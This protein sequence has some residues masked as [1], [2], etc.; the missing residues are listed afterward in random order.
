MR[1][2]PQCKV[3]TTDI[4]SEKFPAARWQTDRDTNPATFHLYYFKHSTLLELLDLAALGCRLCCL[5]LKAHEDIAKNG[6]ATGLG[7]TDRP[8]WI[9]INS[10]DTW[11]F[12]VEMPIAEN[13]IQM[14]YA[15]ARL[16]LYQL[17]SS[18]ETGYEPDG[19][20]SPS[21]RAEIN[22]TPD[23][24]RAFKL[25]RSWIYQC[26]HHH[27][28]C[29]RSRQVTL[30]PRVLDVGLPDGSQ[31]PCLVDGKGKKGEYLTLSHV[32]G[33]NTYGL[34]TAANMKE[35]ESEISPSSL[36]KTF[37]DAIVITGNLGFRYVWIDSL[38][39]VQDSPEDW[40][41]NCHKMS[42][43]FG[44]STLT[45]ASLWSTK[46]GDGIFCDRRNMYPCNEFNSVR[47]FPDSIKDQ[48]PT[49]IRVAP[50]DL[51]YALHSFKLNKRGWVLQERILSP[52]TL[53]CWNSEMF[54]ECRVY[55]ASESQPQPLIHLGGQT[56]NIFQE[57][58]R[59]GLIG[60]PQGHIIAWYLIVEQYSERELT[61]PSDRLLA[62][63]GLARRFCST[64]SV[65]YSAGLWI[66][67]LHRGLLWVSR[68]KNRGQAS[69]PQQ[70][71]SVLAP[72]WSWGDVKTPVVFAWLI[73][74]GFSLYYPIAR[75]VAPSDAD[76]VDVIKYHN[77][78]NSPTGRLKGCIQMWAN[79]V[80]AFYT[81]IEASESPG[82]TCLWQNPGYCISHKRRDFGSCQVPC[83]LDLAY[84][85][86]Q[87][88]YCARIS[89]WKHV[90]G[91]KEFRGL[92]S[93][94]EPVFAYFLILQRVGSRRSLLHPLNRGTFRRIGISADE[95]SI[96]MLFHVFDQTF[97]H[98]RLILLGTLVFKLFSF[99]GN[100]IF[101]RNFNFE[102]RINITFSQYCH[103]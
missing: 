3:F 52:A 90:L 71:A 6:A 14:P 35:R 21:I 1:I 73:E 19:K 86:T 85:V 50:W 103:R 42:T 60:Y 31:R 2:C 48:L 74:W 102:F 63:L 87:R 68:S 27:K 30:P 39:I 38:C 41:A 94:R 20:C 98:P 76:I 15:A 29:A 56:K 28:E 83:A 32:W 62:I 55:T 57:I 88:V 96:V 8:V 9:R 70:T 99:G 72:S 26:L 65:S 97:Y 54:W 17:D 33:G 36:P 34:T 89:T 37:R 93:A 77:L 24:E 82:R 47:I 13:S 100:E 40:K 16:E 66:E 4:F 22:D 91:A 45:I 84:D 25:A 79:I 12:Y 18:G 10:R 95:T 67:D 92:L 53:Y 49:F 80:V 75:I 61:F 58:Q 7:S 5:L 43:I 78:P 64:Y 81:A 59:K 44:S 101:R 51:Y 23:C 11:N 46:S 69:L